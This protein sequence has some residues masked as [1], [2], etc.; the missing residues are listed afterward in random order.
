MLIRV[1][2]YG[3][4]AEVAGT[5]IKTYN[6]VSSFGELRLRIQDDFPEIIHYNYRYCHNK[7]V[8]ADG[9]AVLAEGDEISLLPPFYG[10]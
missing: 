10:G 1:L 7:V 8:M 2:F 9:E 4:L 5:R 3:V 6:D